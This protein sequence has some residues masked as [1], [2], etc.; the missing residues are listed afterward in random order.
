MGVLKG[1]VIFSAGFISGGVL[2]YSYVRSKVDEEINAELAE[3]RESYYDK[4]AII[5]DN[6]KAKEIINEQGY[7]KYYT[8]EGEN[9]ILT[10][11][12]KEVTKN[13]DDN[14]RE[15]Y[16]SEP[17]IITEND[18]AETELYFEKEQV[19]YYLD[20]GA[21]VNAGESEVGKELLNIDDTIGFDNLDEFL[22]QENV[23]VIY[24]RNAALGVDYEVTKIS[25]RYSDI[26]GIGGDD[27]ED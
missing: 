12:I 9:E 7:T 2:T 20:D 13:N 27:D 6:K 22:K 19:E 5:K 1:V 10:N 25:G 3:L 11:R 8:S 17:I 18:F 26:V 23:G 21:L 14:P 16:P 24:I 15:D 4:M